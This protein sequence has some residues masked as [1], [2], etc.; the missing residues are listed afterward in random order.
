[1]VTAI[2]NPAI[3]SSRLQPKALR[4]GLSR[5]TRAV[6]AEEDERASG[7]RTIITIGENQIHRR[8][9][10][11]QSSRSGTFLGETTS[12]ER[13]GR[14]GAVELGSNRVRGR[15]PLGKPSRY[16]RGLR[17]IPGPG[18]AGQASRRSTFG[19]L[20]RILDFARRLHLERR[21][22]H[23]GIVVRVHRVQRQRPERGQKAVRQLSR[24]TCVSFQVKSIIGRKNVLFFKFALRIIGKSLSQLTSTST[25]VD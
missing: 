12:G 23:D 25:K 6:A 3:Y 9:G 24:E 2:V 18:H 13:G 11:K 5:I 14:H 7:R 16:G 10:E 22:L 1:M 4:G 15:R 20:R 21:L 17:R 8:Q 19:L